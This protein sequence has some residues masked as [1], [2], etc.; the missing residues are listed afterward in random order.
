MYRSLMFGVI[1]VLMVLAAGCREEASEARPDA[2][3]AEQPGVGGTGDVSPL[4]AQTWID[5]VTI[6]HEIGQDGSIPPGRTGDDFAP[7]APIHLAM[8]V[9][10]APEN[11]AVKVV[12]YG[13]G[14]ANLHEDTKNVTPNQKY[15]T[16]TAPSTQSWQKGDY[17]A[18]V[19]VGDEK[20]NQQQFQIV[21]AAA[22]G[23]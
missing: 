8:D 1:V 20:V 17:R 13:P 4:N 9:D 22:A 3:T 15:L 10:D 5:D 11:T 16:F 23:K 14:E 6:G 19:W 18:E 7:G 21:D 12:W 2:T